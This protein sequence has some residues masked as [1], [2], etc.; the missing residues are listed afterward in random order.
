[1]LYLLRVSVPDRPGALGALASAVGQAGGDITAVDVVERG[2]SAAIDDL[3][4]ETSNEDVSAAV[5]ASV[6]TVPGAI[7][8]AWQ[9]FME[10]NQLR[11]GVDVVDALGFATSPARAAIIR[12]APALIRARWVVIIEAVADGVAVTQASAGSSRTRWTRLPWFPLASATQIDPDPAWLPHAWGAAPQIAAA[13][14]TGS[15]AALVAV[16]PTG[17]RF[18]RSEV[19]R[20]TGLA[21]VAGLAVSPDDSSSQLPYDG[22]VSRS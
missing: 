4:V 9:P 17:P 12:I 21:A 14:I 11:N 16:R 18:V 5:L 2:S 6:D 22:I 3:L 8:E 7:L 13:P 19:D 1:V 10:G 15:I 20:L